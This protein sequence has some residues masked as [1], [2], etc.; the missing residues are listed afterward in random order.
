MH[1]THATT[2]YAVKFNKV[3]SKR[4]QVSE[5]QVIVR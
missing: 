2:T 5:V 1:Q 3:P 4:R